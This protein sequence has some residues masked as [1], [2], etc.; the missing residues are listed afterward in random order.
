M[1]RRANDDPSLGE[2]ILGIST[3]EFLDGTRL[4][5]VS[6][7]PRTELLVLDTLLPEHDPRS[8]RILQLPPLPIHSAAY[9]VFTRH[10]NSPAG[11]PEFSVDP[12][13]EFFVIF[14]QTEL[15]Y[16]VPA[17]LLQRCMGCVRADNRISWDDWGEDLT[18]LCLS[19]RAVVRL[20]EMKVVALVETL[21]TFE[22]N[23]SVRMYDLSKF[24]RKDIQVQQVGEEDGKCRK[25]LQTP[26]WSGSYQGGDRS[27]IWGIPLGNKFIC[28]HVSLP[29]R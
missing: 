11:Y 25:T 12:A 3:V 18:A 24:A 6:N 23:W 16:V 22:E 9:S 8:W 29:M 7:F 20:V 10:E 14:S 19:G 27:P 15:T 26:T 13:Q 5:A 21:G 28:S 1:F 4:L 2:T 17:E